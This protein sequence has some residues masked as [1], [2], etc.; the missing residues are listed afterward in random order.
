M[1]EVLCVS[2]GAGTIAVNKNDMAY[3]YSGE[4]AEEIKKYTESGHERGLRPLEGELE[5]GSEELMVI[6]HINRYFAK[7]LASLGLP[8]QELLPEQFHLLPH[9]R[10]NAYKAEN[11]V[12]EDIGPAFQE[13]RTA[14]IYID[15]DAEQ[16]NR[17]LLY[18]AMFHEATHAQAFI[19]FVLRGEDPGSYGR[20]GYFVGRLETP[21]AVRLKLRAFNEAVTEKIATEM[22]TTYAEELISLLKLTSEEQDADLEIYPEQ[23]NIL[24]LV[25]QGIADKNRQPIE[26][27]WRRF[28]RGYFGGEMMHLRDIERTFGKGSL[29]VL[30]KLPIT[31]LFDLKLY[32]K[33]EH[34][35]LTRDEKERQALR[36]ELLTEAAPAPDGEN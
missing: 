3:R 10:F 11:V 33:I 31:I 14:A 21:G 9:E 35:F 7:E 25:L 16:D 29:A 28:K 6:E 1:R 15:K 5:K 19:K 2:F 8:P 13:A 34:Y 24:N 18:H 27:V 17:A 12:Y 26:E 4:R 22:I 32:E 20:G 36:Q 23:V 30:D